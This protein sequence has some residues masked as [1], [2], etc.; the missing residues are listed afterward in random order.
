LNL[1]YSLMPYIYAQA[2]D[3]SA[4]GFPMLRTLFFEFP[5]DPTSW[6]IEDEYMFGSDL[7]VAPLVEESNQRSVYLPPGKWIDYQTGNVFDGARWHDITAGDI[8]IVL[9]VKDNSVLPHVKPAQSTSEIDWNNIELRV[10]STNE[11]PVAGRFALPNQ[12]LQ[13]IELRRSKDGYA[14]SHDISGGRIKWNITSA[15]IAA[16]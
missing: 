7:L 2:K 12:D 15:K 1:R 14:L 5:H 9:L 11:S 16:N 6:M 4:K 10:F 8:P 3:S 13:T